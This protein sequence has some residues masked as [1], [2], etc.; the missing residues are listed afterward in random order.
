MSSMKKTGM[1]IFISEE[2]ARDNMKERE[3]RKKGK[4]GDGYPPGIEKKT[5]KDNN[6]QTKGQ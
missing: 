6:R 3:K 2:M 1:E 5:L 4:E